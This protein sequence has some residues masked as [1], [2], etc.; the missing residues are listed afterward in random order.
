MTNCLFYSVF[1]SL[2]LNISIGSLRLSQ[3]NRSFMGIYKGMLEASVFTI[4][5]EGEPVLPYY[6]ENRINKYVTNYLDKN[7]SKYSSDYQIITSLEDK[8]T[9]ELCIDF[10]RSLRIELRA[11]INTFYKYKKSQVFTIY[12]GEEL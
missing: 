8:D 11:K 4:N 10:C 9:G 2:F 7:I 1:F 5:D 6:D 3:I 12:S